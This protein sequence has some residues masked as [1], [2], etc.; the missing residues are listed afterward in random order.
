MLKFG[1]FYLP[2]FYPNV[3]GPAQC[4]REMIEQV[5]YGDQHGF[6][7]AWFVEH[8]FLRHGGILPSNFVF[9][10]ALAMRTRQIRLG[11]GA[12]VMPF[13]DPVRVAEQGA[14]LDCLS[15]GRLDLGVGRG[16]QKAE[17][18]AFEVKMDEA[19]ERVEEGIEIVKACWTQAVVEFHGRFRNFG[20]I[21]VIPKPVQKPHP[22]IWVACFLSKESFEYTAQQGY[23]LLFVAYHVEPD[24]A[25]QRISWYWDAID[26]A[27]RKR[28]DHEAL[29][30]YHAY[31]TEPGEDLDSLKSVVAEPLHEYFA[32]AA[33]GFIPP[34]SESYK[35]YQG[36]RQQFQE[37]ANFD[38]VYPKRLL[39][40]TPDQVIARVEEVAAMGVN[41]ICLIPT[42][43]TLPHEESMASLERFVKYVLPHFRGP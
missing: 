1:L 38:V 4:Y 25:R 34:D 14:M 12:V 8:H 29:V 32:T 39:M 6:D 36:V 43:G 2:S 7:S 41:H 26:R 15:D 28:E 20:P 10:T 31:V 9:L 13:N 21:T 11:T 37:R 30:C 3:K 19:R 33:E 22:P 17:F 23:H 42:F 16:F 24:V 27:G 40:G 35:A 5:E 18:D